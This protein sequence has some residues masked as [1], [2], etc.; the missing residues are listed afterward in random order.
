VRIVAGE[1]RGRPIRAPKGAATRP[2]SDRVR[3]ALFSALT[4]RLGPGLAAVVALDAFAGTGALGLEALSRGAA[5]AVFI[6]SERE[7]RRTLETNVAALGASPRSRIVAGDAFALGSRAALPGGPFG[8]LLLDPP[9]RIE[10]CR[11]AGLLQVQA[12]SGA[13]EPGALVVYELP[14]DAEMEWPEG[15]DEVWVRKYGSTGLRMAVY[16]EGER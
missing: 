12:E 16:G 9:Y 14:A 15:F 6:E 2:T 8:L 1:W 4:A 5:R 7:A 11:V 13:V 10:R 3:E